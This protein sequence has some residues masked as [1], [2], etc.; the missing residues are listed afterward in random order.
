MSISLGP[1]KQV[2]VSAACDAQVSPPPPPS[3]PPLHPPI[4]LA[5]TVDAS[6]VSWSAA[7]QM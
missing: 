2:F 7:C 5:G 1:S 4:I 6:F 3:L